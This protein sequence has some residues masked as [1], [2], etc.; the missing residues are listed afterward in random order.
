MPYNRGRAVE[1]AHIWALKRN[2]RYLDFDKMGGDCTNF[3]SQCLLAGGLPM[4]YRKNFGWYYN[5]PYDR[6]PSWT[7]VQYLY[8]FLTGNKEVG[9]KAVEIPM[10]EVEIGDVI[11]LSFGGDIYSHSLLVV[12]VEYP[13]N[14]SSV[15][16]ATHTYDS[17]YRQLSTYEAMASYRC[18]KIE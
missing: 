6:A 13:A 4:N 3:I 15:R 14:E 17:D 1:Y 9:P 7:S 16:I 12:D 5:S 18:L 2:P 11:Q 8:N 10:G